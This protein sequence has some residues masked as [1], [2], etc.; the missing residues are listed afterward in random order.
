MKDKYN[1]Q[2]ELLKSYKEL[3]KEMLKD[4]K[5]TFNDVQIPNFNVSYSNGEITN[6][7]KTKKEILKW[8]LAVFS[9]WKTN[10]KILD[11]NKQYIYDITYNAFNISANKIGVSFFAK[12]EFDNLVEEKLKKTGINTKKIFETKST[13]QYKKIKKVVNSAV[14]NNLSKKEIVNAVSTNFYN[15]GIKTTS[16]L[17]SN[18][19]KRYQ[20]YSQTTAEADMNM[21]KQWVYSYRSKEPRNWHMKMN[22]QIADIKG[23]FWSSLGGKAQAPREFGSAV[24][25]INCRCEMKLSLKDDFT[26]ETYNRRKIVLDAEKDLL[27]EKNIGEEKIDG[28]IKAFDLKNDDKNRKIVNDYTKIREYRLGQR[29]L[30]NQYWRD[31]TTE[32]WFH[33]KE[34]INELKRIGLI[35]DNYIEYMKQ[36]NYA[37]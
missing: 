3:E 12:K 14:D 30:G 18:E 17:V 31:V 22:G 21:V 36:N 1:E 11:K 29:E 23:Y 4:I 27:K 13:L 5:K 37:R 34:D 35:D 2:E 25:D 8:S 6:K 10:K 15:Q 24:E 28:L 7:Q 20:S 16:N 19:F 32:R 33:S 26:L 9:V